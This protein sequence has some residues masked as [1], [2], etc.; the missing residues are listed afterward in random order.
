M[1]ERK[2]CLCTIILHGLAENGR[3]LR[4]SSPGWMTSDCKRAQTLSVMRRSRIHVQRAPK[5]FG[6]RTTLV[7][8]TTSEM[9]RKVSRPQLPSSS[10]YSSS[11]S[12][13][14]L[15]TVLSERAHVLAVAVGLP[16]RGR[17]FSLSSPTSSSSTGPAKLPALTG[18]NCKKSPLKR[19]FKPPMIK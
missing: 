13:L 8:Q 12:S 1:A 7:R 5:A 6:A 14:S 16:T 9:R 11:M 15:F 10:S 19:N 18:G 17:L 2:T 3:L 4:R